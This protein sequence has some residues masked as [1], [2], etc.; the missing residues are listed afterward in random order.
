MTRFTRVDEKPNI[1]PTVSNP[2]EEV[3]SVPIEV[4][5]LVRFMCDTW[6]SV[7]K[8]AHKNMT[9]ESLGDYPQIQGTSNQ[10]NLQR[11]GEQ[12]H[13]TE[14]LHKAIEWMKAH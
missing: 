9:A 1:K 14:N 4:L 8:W 2:V 10:I 13:N 6:V 12:Q 5:D 7:D 3:V 11:I